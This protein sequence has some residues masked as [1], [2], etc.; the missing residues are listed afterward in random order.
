MGR[1]DVLVNNAIYQGPG[2]MDRILDLPLELAERCLVGDYLHPLLLTQLRPAR[3][4]RARRGPPGQ[5]ALRGGLH[6]AAGAGRTRRVGRGLRRRQSRLS[7]GHRHV[8]RRVRRGRAS[9]PSPSRP[10][11]RSPSR[12]GRRVR[13]RSSWRPATCRRRPRWPARSRPG[14]ATTPRPAA[15]PGRWCRRASYARSWDW[16]RVGRRRRASPRPD[17]AGQAHRVGD[18]GSQPEAATSAAQA[19]SAPYSSSRAPSLS[20]A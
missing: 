17:D 9:G 15:T 16:C 8:P 10:G 4:A 6:D 12:C 7:P 19:A 3:D 1:V 11:S 5:H 20:P 2:T 14:S 13:T 18:T